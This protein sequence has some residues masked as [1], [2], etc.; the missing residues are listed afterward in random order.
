MRPFRA[1][2]GAVDADEMLELDDEGER[3]VDGIAVFD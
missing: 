3:W 2:Q 1:K